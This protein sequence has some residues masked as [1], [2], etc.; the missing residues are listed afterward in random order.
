MN[1]DEK[2]VRLN[3]SETVMTVRAQFDGRGSKVHGS[4][5]VDTILYTGVDQNRIKGVGKRNG[6]A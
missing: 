4:P 3:G 6:D 1:M 5:V 2:I